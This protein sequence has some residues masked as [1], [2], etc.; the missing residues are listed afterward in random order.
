MSTLAVW[1]EIHVDDMARAKT[2]YQSLFDIT[3]KHMWHDGMPA[4]MDY[5]A[6][7]DGSMT[8]Y[9]SSG[10]LVHMPGLQA[11]G[12]NTVVY[13]HTADCA[14]A[15]AKAVSLGG[16]LFR[17]KIKIGEHGHITLVHDTEGNLIGLHSM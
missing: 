8:Q 10:A 15:A 14:Q 6:F 11:G 1:F 13:F 9:G 5:W 12:A 2:F 3:L 17:D 16:K 4:G 7:P